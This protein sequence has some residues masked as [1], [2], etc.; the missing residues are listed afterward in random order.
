V[1]ATSPL[2][3]VDE[4]VVTY[5]QPGFHSTPLR[6]LGGVSLEVYP[7][8]TLGLVGESGSGKST[9]GRAVLG[10]VP[11]AK[12]T[13]EFD[14]HDITHADRRQRRKVSKELQVVFQD[15]YS[16]LNPAR[17]IAQTLS[18]P[19]LVHEKLSRAETAHRVRA[20]L[21][22]VGLPSDSAN[23]YPSNFSGGQ[24]QRIA[25]ARALIVAPRLVICDEPVSALDLS[26]QA[27]ILNLLD[28]LQQE[29]SLSYLFISHD[30]AVVRHAAQRVVV[31]YQGL[32]MESG[33]A[34]AVCDAPAHP[35]S[36]ALLASVPVPDPA[37]QRARHDLRQRM[38]RD[39]SSDIG[40]DAGCPFA[41]RCPYVVDEC[42][43]D[44]PTLV[45]APNGNLVA[46]I[47]ADEISAS[48]VNAFAMDAVTNHRPPV[49]AEVSPSATATDHP[50]G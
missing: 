27:Q 14:G 48:V 5:K 45:T 18:E 6:A 21:Q 7:G 49:G 31:L 11:I 24:R 38:A 46:C 41:P 40:S 28:D 33:P 17:T 42:R 44:L 30:L 34:H 13:V 25:I 4:L 16:S 22:R 32:I 29:L 20:A 26:I 50:R 8:E 23:R 9:L 10:L 47:R 3:D 35:Y 37:L 2:L 1:T 15:P 19:L 39:L 12:G 36:Q 43:R